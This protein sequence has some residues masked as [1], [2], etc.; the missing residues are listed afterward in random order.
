MHSGINISI[1]V[2]HFNAISRFAHH[3]KRYK[4]VFTFPDDPRYSS[5]FGFHVALHPL[6]SAP[7]DR[8][9]AVGH[10]VKRLGEELIPGIRN[11][12]LLIANYLTTLF[13]Q[14]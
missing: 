8:T 13:Q 6:L 10:V 3:L 5:N 7:E 11:E 9:E 1:N 4:D 14:P 2:V 12:V